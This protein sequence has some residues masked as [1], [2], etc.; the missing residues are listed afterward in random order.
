MQEERK[1]KKFPFLESEPLRQYYILMAQS[2]IITF[3][4][5]ADSA[6]FLRITTEFGK[7][8]S[9]RYVIIVMTSY[10]NLLRCFN[11]LLKYQSVSKCPNIS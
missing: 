7:A 8:S 3:K 10:S 4:A 2:V 1:Q 9:F 6:I 11:G 5:F